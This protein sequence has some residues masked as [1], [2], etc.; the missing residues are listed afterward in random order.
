MTKH[1]RL[2]ELPEFA[3]PQF[4]RRDDGRGPRSRLRHC[5]EPR[6][7]AYRCGPSRRSD[8]LVRDRQRRQ[9]RGHLR[10]GRNGSTHFEHDGAT[11]CR[12]TR[13]VVEGHVRRPRL[14]RSQIRRSGSRR[15]N[16]RRQLEHVDELR[17]D[18]PGRRGRA[19]HLDQ[20][21]VPRC[22]AC[23]RASATRRNRA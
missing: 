6:C 3:S 4:P 2:T 12:R 22:S 15:A 11:D 23:R 1:E 5:A 18:E 21:R 10:Q 16:H 20:G 14:E 13:S 7:Y 17:R 8:R 19:P 9:G